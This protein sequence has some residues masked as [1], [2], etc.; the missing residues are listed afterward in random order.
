MIQQ[1]LDLGERAGDIADVNRHPELPR[2]L[3]GGEQAVHRLTG[4]WATGVGILPLTILLNVLGD[5]MLTM[6]LW[7]WLLIG[8]IAVLSWLVLHFRW[9]WSSRRENSPVASEAER[10]PD[11]SNT[12]VGE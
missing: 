1:R 7:A 9:Q 3:R 2:D 5:R 8:A 10:N 11:Q 4:L 6:P 12:D